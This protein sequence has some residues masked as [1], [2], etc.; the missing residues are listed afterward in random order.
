MDQYI[1]MHIHI[2]PEVD[3]GANDENEMKEMLKICI[4][5]GDPLYHRN[6]T[7]SSQTRKGTTGSVAEKG[8]GAF[9]SGP[10][11]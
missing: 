4:Q 3:D 9:K 1:D 7:S 11:H 8:S 2:L 6:A 5:R 10:R